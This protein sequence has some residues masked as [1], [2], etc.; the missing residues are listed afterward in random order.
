MAWLGMVIN[1]LFSFTT[2]NARELEEF[3]KEE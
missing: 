3:L 2:K 1:Q